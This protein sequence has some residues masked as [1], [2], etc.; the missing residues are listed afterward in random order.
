MGVSLVIGRPVFEACAQ[1]ANVSDTTS[2]MR[3]HGAGG[4]P[5][6]NFRAI[7]ARVLLPRAPQGRACRRVVPGG[8]PSVVSRRPAVDPDASMEGG[9][10]CTRRRAARRTSC[11]T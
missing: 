2:R 7:G 11:P 9:Y 3:L 10:P 8:V 4:R 6:Y 1:G 5:C